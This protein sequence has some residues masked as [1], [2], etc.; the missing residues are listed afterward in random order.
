MYLRSCCQCVL[1]LGPCGFLE[2][3]GSRMR[4]CVCEVG[5]CNGAKASLSDRTAHLMADYL[6]AEVSLIVLYGC[7]KLYV[8]EVF[9]T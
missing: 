7:L 8:L 1:L 2:E 9:Q 5:Q 4:M 6:L 3:D